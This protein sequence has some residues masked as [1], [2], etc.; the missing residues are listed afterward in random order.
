[1]VEEVIPF[2]LECDKLKSVLR[3]T[4]PVGAE[5]REDSAQHSWSLAILAMT[6]LPKLA[7]QLD[8]LRVLK[9]LLVHDIVE[10]DAGDTFVYAAQEGKAEKEMAAA[11][12]LFGLLPV[13]EGGEFMTLWQ[14]F[15]LGETPEAAFANSLDRVLPILQNYHN[16]GRSWKANGVVFE[17]VHARNQMIRKG[18]EE[19]WNFI[20]GL[21]L[22]AVEKGF[23]P[24]RDPLP[25]TGSGAGD[26]NEEK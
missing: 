14:E 15:E 22:D 20:E 4:Y 12:R 18:S 6:L 9:M 23:L 10:I 24:R 19:L 16:G 13:A 5:R 2:I 26:E 8:A 21:I 11:Q 25:A 17:Q 7:P 3:Q 1:M